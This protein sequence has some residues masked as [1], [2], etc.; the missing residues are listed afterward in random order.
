MPALVQDPRER[1]E[2]QEERQK[3]GDTLA[4]WVLDTMA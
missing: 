2:I 1:Q 4:R 3:L